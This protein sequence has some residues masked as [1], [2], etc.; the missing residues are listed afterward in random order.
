MALIQFLFRVTISRVHIGQEFVYFTAFMQRVS[1]TNVFHPMISRTVGGYGSPHE[2]GVDG[3]ERLAQ[4][5]D[6]NT[7][8]QSQKKEQ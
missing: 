5:R 1:K 8:G 6:R 7:V 2:K 3:G 4:Q